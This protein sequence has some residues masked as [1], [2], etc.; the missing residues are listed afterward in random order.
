MQQCSAMPRA[1]LAVRSSFRNSGFFRLFPIQKRRHSIPLKI[2]SIL[3]SVRIG[4]I[5]PN[6][7][8]RHFHTSVP[9]Q[10]IT[11]D[12]TEFKYYEMDKKGHL[13]IKNLYLDPCLDMFSGEVLSYGFSKPSSA[14]GILSPQNRQ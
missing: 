3:F 10:K 8:H 5:T 12:T 9:H 4:Q 1:A 11:T 7:I 6:R 14:G 2:D 13:V